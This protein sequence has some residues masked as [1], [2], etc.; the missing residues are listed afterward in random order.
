MYFHVE[1]QNF[2]SLL[3]DSELNTKGCTQVYQ[4]HVVNIFLF[5]LMI[6]FIIYL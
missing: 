3:I 4:T 2:K 1:V 5:N 6:I